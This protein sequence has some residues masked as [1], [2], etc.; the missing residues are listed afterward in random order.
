MMMVD[1]VFAAFL[2]SYASQLHQCRDVQHGECLD[3]YVPKDFDCLR[4][5]VATYED[6]CGKF[7]DYSRKFIR[8]LV[9][10]CENPSMSHSMAKTK[11]KNACLK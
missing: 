7:D 3:Q 11:L 2:D 5:M 10:E 8:Y 1:E 6:N 4:S 9:R